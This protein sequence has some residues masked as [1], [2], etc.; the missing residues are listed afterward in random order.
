LVVDCGESYR[1]Q[2]HLRRRQM[3]QSGASRLRVG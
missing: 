3:N 2:T 1:Q